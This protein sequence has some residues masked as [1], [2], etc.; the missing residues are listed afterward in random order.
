M[1]ALKVTGSLIPKS[2]AAW[3]AAAEQ[4]EGPYSPRPGAMSIYFMGGL[5]ALPFD[6]RRIHGVHA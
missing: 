4:A 3:F 2:E 1:S 5:V 6:Q